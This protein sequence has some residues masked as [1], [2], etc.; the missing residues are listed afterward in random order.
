MFG[1]LPADVRPC[2]DTGPAT[3]AREGVGSVADRLPMGSLCSPTT[4]QGRTPMPTEPYPCASEGKYGKCMADRVPI[5]CRPTGCR[6]GGR[7][8]RLCV[9]V[10]RHSHGAVHRVRDRNLDPGN[11]KTAD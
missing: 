1:L 9:S 8:V 3:V 5:G 10:A 6:K 11:Y 2:S 7:S 4:G